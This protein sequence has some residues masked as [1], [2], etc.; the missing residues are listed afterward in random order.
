M[1]LRSALLFALLAGT[2]LA[3]L[4]LAP[5][6]MAQESGL[7]YTQTLSPDAVRAV[8]GR[9]NALA[10]YQG[11]INGAWG[12]DSEAALRNFQ[13]NN[14]L[15]VTGQMNQATA[16]TMG[17]D[18]AS[19]VGAAG[20]VP[21]PAPAPLATAAPPPPP[22]PAPAPAPAPQPAPAAAPG[23]I[24]ALSNNSVRIIQARLRQ[25]GFYNGAIDGEWGGGS[26]TALQA[27]QQA[28][29]LPADG[30][31]NAASV[32]AMGIDPASM[33]PR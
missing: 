2:A 14:G 32:Q 27:F 20:Q 24:F 29:G 19:L 25:L 4:C 23:P 3:P 28:H 5:P 15:Q 9:L 22:A 7:S 12:P 16:A 6:A 18:V 1:N 17:L 31:L 11:P 30:H 8:Q 21:A 10:G 13:Q 33:Q 26:Q